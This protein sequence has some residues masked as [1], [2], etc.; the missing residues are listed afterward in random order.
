MINSLAAVVR[1]LAEN[2]LDA[3]AHRVTIDLWPQAWRVRVADNGQGMARAD[4]HQ[5]AVPHATSKIRTE[6]DLRRVTTLGFRGQA[7]HSLANLGQL[8]VCSRP[9]GGEGHQVIYDHQGQVSAIRGIAMAPGTIVTVDDLFAPCPQRRPGNPH[10][11]LQGVQEVIQ[12]LALCYPQ[13]A[14]QVRHQDRP[15]LSLWPAD[16]AH[17][18][19]PQVLR[20][21]QTDDLKRVCLRPEPPTPVEGPWELELVMGLPERCH[22]HRPDWVKVAVNQ[23]LIQSSELEQT[24]LASC[25]RTLPRGRFPVCFLHLR[26]PPETVDWNRDPDKARIYLDHLEY[27]QEQAHRAIGQVLA[28]QLSEPA[29]TRQLG[30][31]LQVAEAGSTYQVS[32]PTPLGRLRV[33]A[34]V[35]NT[36]LLA[37]HPGGV[38]LVEQHIAHERVLYEQIQ[39]HWR[40][41][42]LSAPL[43]LRDLSPPQVERLLELGLVVEPFGEQTWAVR[44]VPALLEGHQDRGE[45]IRE[46]AMGGDLEAAQVTLACRSAVRNGAPLTHEQMQT[47]LDQWSQTRDSRTCPHGRPICLN[48]PE[49]AL[50]QFFRRPW[51]ITRSHPP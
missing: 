46:L 23:R 47:I 11:A 41:V 27:W 34:Q 7:L 35:H 13:V 4:L 40:L 42:P 50:A 51:L 24:L 19:L 8:E 36:Y 25:R 22:R 2:A 37:E 9:E 14:W 3:G 15:W 17:Q 30:R 43:L 10:Q 39:A 31:I 29:Q 18:I 6:A 49:T 32:P 26:V 16:C 45:V 33:L 44:T 28:G 38:C 20:R 12:A 48:L 21:L 5:A 1:E